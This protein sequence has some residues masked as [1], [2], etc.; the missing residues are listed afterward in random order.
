M[1]VLGIETTCDETAAS[2][3]ALRADGGGEILSNEIFSQ[4][5]AHAAYGGVVPEIAA[6]A[7]VEV[8][9]RILPIM[10]DVAS[11][12]APIKISRTG[13]LGVLDADRA[14]LG[15]LT[16]LGSNSRLVSFHGAILNRGAVL[17]YD[18]PGQGVARIQGDF[19][20]RG[21]AHAAGDDLVG[22]HPARRG[23]EPVHAALLIERHADGYALVTLNRPEALNALNSALFKDLSDFLDAVEHDDSV[24]CLILTG[25]GDIVEVQQANL[26]GTMADKR[27]GQNKPVTVSGLTITGADAANYTLTGADADGGGTLTALVA[28]AVGTRLV[29]GAPGHAHNVGAAYAYDLTVGPEFPDMNIEQ[30]AMVVEHAFLASRG[31]KAPQGAELYAAASVHWRAG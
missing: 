8:I 1:R 25:S 21:L 13:A 17:R 26:S 10:N 6:R 24:R 22:Q 12:D 11:V 2:V 14:I 19:V 7:H 18:V 16:V 5:E 4:V 30:Q 3:V 29:I 15:A 28:P 31:G 27:A 23:D 9:D 20:K